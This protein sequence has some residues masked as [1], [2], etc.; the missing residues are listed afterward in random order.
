MD[1]KIIKILDYAK[2]HSSFYRDKLSG[3]ND[4]QSFI[5]NFKLTKNEIRDNYGKLLSDEYQDNMYKLLKISVTSGTSGAPLSIYWS[6]NDQLRSNMCIW[7]L[8]KKYYDIEPDDIYCSTFNYSY[9]DSRVSKVEKV[10][11]EGNNIMFCKM[12]QDENSLK[13]YYETMIKYSPKW[14]MIQPSF[15]V[16]LIDYLKFKKLP[17]IDSIQYVEFTGECLTQTA[18][19]IV[20]SFFL[21]KTANLY[22]C[23]ET[24]V[25]AYECPHGKMHILSD[26]V[27]VDVDE[28]NKAYIT[29]LQNHA[30]PLIK[31]DI[32]DIIEKASDYTCECGFKGEIIE[33]ILGRTTN[34]IQIE[35]GIN[36]NEGA[37]AYCVDRAETI[38]GIGIKQY[39][40]KYKNKVLTICINCVQTNSSWIEK[41]IAETNNNFYNIYGKLNIVYEISN[42]PIVYESSD[43]GRKFS[44]LEVEK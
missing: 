8:R 4:Y 32:G 29:S 31:Y 12:F 38:V 14:L 34:Q 21:C 18:R 28:N 15:A 16:K 27:A 44:L 25:I 1:D 13:L 5:T 43:N 33:N 6:I 37:I 11:V 3:I 23:M 40:A 7:R 10:R 41:F 20:E 36:I 2:D 24:N 22:G 39:K 30:F 19:K 26:N 17:P 35:E 9:S 42:N